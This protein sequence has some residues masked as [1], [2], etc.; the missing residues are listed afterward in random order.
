MTARTPAYLK[1]VF[2]QGDIP[3]GTDYEDVFDSYLNVET[4]AQQTVAGRVSFTNQVYSSEINSAL[5]SATSVIASFAS[6]QT[7]NTGFLTAGVATVSAKYL[8]T[9]DVSANTTV[10]A[11]AT[12][13]GAAVSFA[14]YANG[15]HNSFR[16]PASEIGRVQTLV[17]A[18]TT[19]IKIFPAVS[20]RFLVTAVNASLNILADRVATIY[21]KGDDRYGIQIG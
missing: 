2:E 17:N 1:S 6:A 18:S 10:Q 19:T 4:S 20:A 8:S 15:Q 14:I 21:H 7:I 11:T 5:V 13:L 16:L 3:Q 9:Q 12:I